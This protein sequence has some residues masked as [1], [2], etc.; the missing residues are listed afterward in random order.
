MARP[1][2]N[3]DAPDTRTQILRAARIEIAAQGVAAPL[4]AIAARC[5][6]RRPSLLHHFPSKAALLDAV[7]EDILRMARERL[8]NA[9]GEGSGDYRRTMQGIVSVLRDLEAEEQGVGGAI[10]H[11]MLA[12]A[13]DGELSRKM[14]AFIDIIH[15]TV[16]MAGVSPE[17]PPQDIR[18]AL[19]HLVMGEFTRMALGPRA[20]ALWGDGDGVNPLFRSYF[21]DGEAA[22][23]RP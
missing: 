22:A 14:G 20:Q 11:A 13:G 7:T 16:V 8:L 4:E 17:V 15:A 5:G 2:K 3:P 1:R 10:M 12:E 9:I 21:I 18:A 6:I 23:I 19:A